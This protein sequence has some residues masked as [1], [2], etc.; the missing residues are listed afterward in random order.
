MFTL[1]F[2]YCV[3]V[4][5]GWISESKRALY[6][7]FLYPILIMSIFY[8][9]KK[10]IDTV[11]FLLTISITLLILLRKTNNK[12]VFYVKWCLHRKQVI[13]LL[14]YL[15][16]LISSENFN[17]VFKLILNNLKFIIQSIWVFFFIFTTRYDDISVIYKK[18]IPNL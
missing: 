12:M 18:K 6:Y 14:F 7:I 5:N 2:F 8:I 3:C 13:L 10:M 15:P 17:R 11:V 16:S 4:H 9:S 1:L